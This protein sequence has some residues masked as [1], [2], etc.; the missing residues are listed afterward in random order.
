VP[1][2]KPYDL[3]RTKVCH[4]RTYYI[5]AKWKLL[6][7]NSR[8]CYHC[9]VGHPQYC[10]A[11]GF[12]AA[13]DS[14]AAAEEE[15]SIYASQQELLAAE[16]IDSSQVPFLPGRRTRVSA[17]SLSCPCPIFYLKSAATTRG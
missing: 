8:E 17:F 4:A 9:G 16:G 5:R 10:R 3:G 7:E 6:V 15:Y 11:V 1:R 14:Q 2:L 13:I 12:A